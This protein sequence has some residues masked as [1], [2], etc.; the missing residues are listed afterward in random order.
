MPF[1]FTVELFATTRRGQLYAVSTR[2]LSEFVSVAAG[3][4]PAYRCS[5][6]DAACRAGA[7]RHI[8]AVREEAT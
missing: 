1:K 8:E 4:P 2:D 5:G 3:E 6:S 7:C